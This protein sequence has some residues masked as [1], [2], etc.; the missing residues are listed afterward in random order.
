VESDIVRA[1]EE[2][3]EEIRAHGGVVLVTGSLQTAAPVLRWLH[4]R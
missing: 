3:V 4:E 1:V 2:A